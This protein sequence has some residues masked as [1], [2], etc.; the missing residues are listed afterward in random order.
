LRSYSE[1][2]LDAGFTDVTSKPLKKDIAREI[3]VKHGRAVQ[4]DPLKLMLKALRT[5]SLTQ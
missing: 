1:G 2:I 3:L 5:K 4:V